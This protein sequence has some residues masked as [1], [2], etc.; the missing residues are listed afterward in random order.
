MM[1]SEVFINLGLAHAKELLMT[2]CG[3]GPE[4][5]AFASRFRRVG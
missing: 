5:E 3:D 1:R 2:T 4:P